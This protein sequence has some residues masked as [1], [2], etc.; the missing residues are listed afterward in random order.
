MPGMENMAHALLV[1]G[2]EAAVVAVGGGKA[3]LPELSYL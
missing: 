2:G 3:W 1:G